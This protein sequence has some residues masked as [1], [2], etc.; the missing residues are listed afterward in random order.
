MELG[1]RYSTDLVGPLQGIVQKGNKLTHLLVR[2]EPEL[3]NE[4]RLLIISGRGSERLHLQETT[5][6]LTANVV[7]QVARSCGLHHECT[8][9]PARIAI[10]LVQVIEELSELYPHD[11][12]GHADTQ[13]LCIKLEQ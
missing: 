12:A 1:L 6:P 5:Q 9:F 11:R 3:L 13:F 7:R 10:R 8:V 4:S 2:Q